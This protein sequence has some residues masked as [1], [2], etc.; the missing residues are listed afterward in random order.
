MI[1]CIASLTACSRA[2]QFFVYGT[3]LEVQ[4]SGIKSAMSVRAVE[5]YIS[6]LERVLSPTV[7]G[8]DLQRINSAKVGEPI[9]C[10][11]ATMQIY[12]VA[13]KVYEASG[14]AYDPSIYPL[15]RLWQFSGDLFDG[16]D[17]F[18]LPSDEQIEQ[19]KRLVGLDRAFEVN[20]ENSTITKLIEGAMLDF[21]GVAKG[22]VVQNSLATASGKTLVNLGGNIGAVGG[23]FNVGIANPSRNG[24]E[25]ITPYFAKFKLL[26][27]ECVSTS[28]DYER[29][30]EVTTDAH[31][32]IYH[33][34][35]NPHT[36]APADTSGSDGVVSCSVVTSDG[37]LGDAVAT[38]VV[39]LGKEK[40]AK[41][42]R[43][44]SLKGLIIDGDMN[45]LVI[46]DF[47]V[48][49]KTATFI[50]SKDVD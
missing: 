18:T 47:D 44:L 35:I 46:G 31:T 15:V 33:H 13:S 3:R 22:Y 26:D 5:G 28:G 34:I 17:G 6:S 40:G 7:E 36:G 19:T 1:F 37:A 21:G 27:G 4:S 10:Q 16:V 50:K 8:S 49:L 32:K 29:Y 39:V 30:Y 2:E 20:Y 38:A 12:K 43:D 25:F 9:E 24:R 45:A 42:M 48:E 41:L 14:G 23:S 11:A